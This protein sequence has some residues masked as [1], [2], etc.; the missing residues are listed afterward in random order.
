MVLPHELVEQALQYNATRNVLDIN[1]GQWESIKEETLLLG[2]LGKCVPL[3]DFSGSMNGVPKLVS[4]ALGILVSEIN[5]PAFRDH[6][7]TFDAEP[8]WHSF[9]GKKT[10]K[11][12][13]DSV[14]GYL[15]VGLNTDFYRACMKVLD[16]MKQG[17][18]P[19]GE[20]PE[21]LL[22]LTDMGFD[23]ASNPHNDTNIVWKTQLEKIRDAFRIAGEELWGVGN[24]WRPPRIVIRN[25]RA[26]YK[27]FHA[28]ADQDGVVQLSGWSPSILKALQKE[29]VKV[30]TPYEG[31]RII[32]DDE[33]Y[34]PV[35]RV[36]D[37]IRAS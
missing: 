7:L 8:S 4:L 14:R 28:K 15:G 2:G 25:L 13:L 19:V 34:D 29:G 24:G 17:R 10:L 1:Q 30:A 20:E 23:A 36:W 9:I 31:L 18:V 3:C 32:L 5:H 22:V 35:R 21:D 37:E 27:D 12:K 26:E 6:I 11:A 16:K 33:R